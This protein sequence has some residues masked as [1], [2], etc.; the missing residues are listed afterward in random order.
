MG[1][2]KNHNTAYRSRINPR[3]KKIRGGEEVK[4]IPL[5]QGWSIYNI[6]IN[7]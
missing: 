3:E 1:T 7:E 6:D 4:I 2:G 5:Q